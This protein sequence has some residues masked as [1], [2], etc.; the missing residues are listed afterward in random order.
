MTAAICQTGSRISSQK[1]V[2][3]IAAICPAT[4]TQRSVTSSSRFLR[5]VISWI[6][7]GVEL[8][9]ALGDLAGFGGAG[10]DGPTL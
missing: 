10:S 8:K 5:L 2:I 1:L 3:A 4:A 6:E 7:S 9:G